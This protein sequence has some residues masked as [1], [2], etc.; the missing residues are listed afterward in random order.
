MHGHSVSDFKVRLEKCT[1]AELP[2]W[3]QDD[4]QQAFIAFK[5]SC[6]R[7]CDDGPITDIYN[8]ALTAKNIISTDDIRNY[9]ETYFQPFQVLW[10]E[11]QGLVTG[12]FEPVLQGS[13]HK[14][15]DFA[16]PVYKKPDDLAALIDDN[17]RAK[18]NSQMT[19]MRKTHDGL[20]PYP[21]RKEIELGALDGKKLE[22][23]FLK[24][25]ISA[26]FMHVQGSAKII[27]NNNS[28]LPSNEKCIR[29]TYAAKNGHP[30]TSIGKELI[31]RGYIEKK[32]MC[33]ET[34]T[35]WLTDNKEKAQEI[36][37]LNESYIFFRE[38]SDI[39]NKHGPLGAQKV[40]L[41][42]QRSLAVDAS[43]HALGTL[44][45][46]SAPD[47]K[48]TNSKGFHQLMTAQDVGSAIIGPERGD[49]FWGCGEKAG[50]WAGLTC[51]SAN[52]YVLKPKPFTQA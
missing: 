17:E 22:I 43:I 30:Y 31:K 1:F 13:R 3:H 48:L 42:P 11:P 46:V 14:T 51:H 27:L 36:M 10:S 25:H 24:D 9:F 47:L 52:F 39:E 5:R 40:P 20:K 50:S 4:L 34:L 45:W 35:S 21:T 16:I 32:S 8:L 49:I 7:T 26:Y 23:V 37:W 19:Y 38:L 41:T 29:L 18:Y 44:V 28:N 6:Q 33:L 15:K 12:Y 2:H